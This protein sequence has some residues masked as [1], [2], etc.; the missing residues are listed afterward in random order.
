MIP[1][2]QPTI[3]PESD[4]EE[5]AFDELEDLVSSNRLSVAVG[6]AIQLR[7]EVLL[8]GDRIRGLK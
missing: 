2:E 5:D 1:F 3:C 8:N 7:K 6:W 4:E